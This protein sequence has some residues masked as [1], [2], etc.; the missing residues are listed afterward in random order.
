MLSR[1]NKKSSV[2][3]METDQSRLLKHF[4][5]NRSRQTWITPPW[6]AVSF[7]LHVA[8]ESTQKK[9]FAGLRFRAIARSTKRWHDFS[10]LGGKGSPRE[11]R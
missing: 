8:S 10:S 3:D 11:P 7:Q 1:T 9:P 5:V 4:G 6:R 2:E